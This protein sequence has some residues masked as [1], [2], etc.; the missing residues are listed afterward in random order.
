M[1]KRMDLTCSAC[2]TIFSPTTHI[3]ARWAIAGAGAVI[4]GT[5]TES[6]LGGLV[7]GG[8]SYLVAAAAD[9][10]YFAKRCP[11]C[12]KLGRSLHDGRAPEEAEQQPATP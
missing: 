9:E 2:A 7:F 6:V 8:V 12:G 1:K 3:K 4:G 5:A 11:N 10:A